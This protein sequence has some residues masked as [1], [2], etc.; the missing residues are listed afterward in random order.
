MTGGS[1]GNQ[2]AAAPPPAQAQQEANNG[3]CAYELRQFL[4]CAEN[5]SDISLCYGFNEALKQCKLNNGKY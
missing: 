5:Q 3:P 2:V 4:Q 1:A